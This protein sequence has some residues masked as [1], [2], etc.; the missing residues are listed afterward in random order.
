MF[1]CSFVFTVQLRLASPG[2][3]HIKLIKEW[4]MRKNCIKK[5][6]QNSSN[7]LIRKEIR[8]IVWGFERSKIAPQACF[9]LGGIPNPS[10]GRPRNDV[11]RQLLIRP[12]NWCEE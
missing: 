4:A 9:G 6:S 7:F 3:L 12:E 8:S 11:S 10:H 2:L 5:T 1:R